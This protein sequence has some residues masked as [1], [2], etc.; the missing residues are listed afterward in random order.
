[1][2]RTILLLA[3]LTT[4]LVSGN[5][6]TGAATS[7]AFRGR[8]VLSPYIGLFQGNNAGLNSYFAM[9]DRCK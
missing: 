2:A 1:M 9:C 4:L 8:P 3:G 6:A 7:P 5:T